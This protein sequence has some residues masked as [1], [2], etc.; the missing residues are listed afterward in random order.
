M[1]RVAVT[2]T[3]LAALYLGVAPAS[4]YPPGTLAWWAAEILNNQVPGSGIVLND[5]GADSGKFYRLSATTKLNNYYPYP[6]FSQTG[7]VRLRAR[8]TY[9]CGGWPV[10]TMVWTRE[11]GSYQVNQR[12]IS[13]TS[14]VTKDYGITVTP[15]Y[16]YSFEVRF[17]YSCN[18]PVDLDYVAV[19]P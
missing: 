5:P 6:E 15:G 4:A 10:V 19:Y 1:K 7:H 8:G 11:D 13:S 14:W 17:T 3:L 18:R 12:A 2:V 9:L 16:S